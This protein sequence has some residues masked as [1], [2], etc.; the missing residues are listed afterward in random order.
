MASK[1]RETFRGHR[2]HLAALAVLAMWGLG[3]EFNSWL[4]ESRPARDLL[5]MTPFHH[6]EVSR[7][8]LD[9]DGV[10]IAG[11]MIKRRC[12]FVGLSAYVRFADGMRERTR[13]DTTPE[14]VR[15]PGG[16]RPASREGQAWGP[17][18]ILRPVH[19]ARAVWWQV[20][21]HH[22]C[23]GDTVVQ[24]NLFAEGPWLPEV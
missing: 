19:S 4:I 17:W 9:P 15:R 21:A 13:L 3:P 12:E 16:D 18:L 7:I 22:R 24:T 20:Y 14:D 1:T 5:G 23:P 8:D 6:V 2:W 11:E 10:L